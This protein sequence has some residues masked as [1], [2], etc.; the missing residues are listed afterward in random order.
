MILHAENVIQVGVQQAKS[1]LSYILQRL[2]GI[3]YSYSRRQICADEE[4]VSP[5]TAYG[6]SGHEVTALPANQS[7]QRTG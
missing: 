5:S 7:F 1:L 2:T 6:H 3:H 4:K